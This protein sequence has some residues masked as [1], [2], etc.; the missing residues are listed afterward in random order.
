MSQHCRPVYVQYPAPFNHSFSVVHCS[1][2]ESQRPLGFSAD[3]ASSMLPPTPVQPTWRPLNRILR[4]QAV[5]SCAGP[6]GHVTVSKTVQLESNKQSHPVNEQG[7]SSSKDMDPK[8]SERTPCPAQ[9]E[10][11]NLNQLG[12]ERDFEEEIEQEEE[13]KC[14]EAKKAEENI[15]EDEKNK[16]AIDS[17]HDTDTE[18][19][20]DSESE[21]ANRKQPESAAWYSVYGELAGY[22]TDIVEINDD[23]YIYLDD[24]VTEYD[25]TEYEPASPSSSE[26]YS[27]SESESEPCFQH[28][29]GILPHSR[30]LSSDGDGDDEDE[31]K[32]SCLKCTF[33]NSVCA[34]RCSMCKTRKS[35]SLLRK[36]G[37]ICCDPEQG[38]SSKTAALQAQDSEQGCSSN[39]AA[40]QTQDS[41]IESGQ[42]QSA[43]LEELQQRKNCVV[44]LTK[45]V[46]TSLVHKGTAHLVCCYKC[47]RKL[48]TKMKPCPICRR[49]IQQI[50]LTFTS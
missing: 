26:P 5:D 39:M 21:D 40:L 37:K 12:E 13:V 35:K 49:P 50:V 2:N 31:D 32:W 15:V 47:A 46:S 41:G 22:E 30:Y 4:C 29:R 19:R 9:A 6:S 25:F 20:S 43:E 34:Y 14:R 3:C 17:E 48:M 10:G 27:E 24:L 42:S 1:N 16:T 23:N 33:L 8:F 38:C 18:V 7:S 45:R 11:L 36:I 44:C 28:Y